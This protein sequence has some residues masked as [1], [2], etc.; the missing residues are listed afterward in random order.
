MII[1]RKVRM[2]LGLVIF[3]L[4]T[5]LFLDFTG[6]IHAWFGWLAKMQFVAAITSSNV[7]VVV[8]LLLLT[9]LFGRIYCSVICPLGVFQDVVLDTATRRKKYRFSFS[10]AKTP[11]RIA[12]LVL[13]VAMFIAGVS[14][15]VVILEPYSIYGRIASNLFAPIWQFGNNI[16]AFFAE[17]VD[18]YAFYS[19]DIWIKSAPTFIIALISFVVIVVLA[20]RGGRTFCNT[21]CPVGTVLGFLAKYSFYKPRIDQDKCNSCGLCEKSCKSSCIDSKSKTIDYSRCVTCLDCT[22]VC[23]KDALHYSKSA[24]PSLAATSETKTTDN[25]RK[26]FLLTSLLLGRTIAKAQEI[27]TDGGLSVI[28]DKKVPSRATHV[29]P[30][31]SVGIKQFKNKCTGCQLC[32]SVCPSQ[33]L[34]PSSDLSRFMQPEMSFENGYCRPECTA[35]SDVCPTGAIISVTKEEK[36]AISIGTAT[37]IKDNCVV[38]TDDVTCGNCATRCPSGAI[39]MIPVSGTTTDTPSQG[40]GTSGNAPSGGQQ[41]RGG[42]GGGQDRGGQGGG[43][44]R[45]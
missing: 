43:Q 3:A 23:K 36:S 41:D 10:K 5:L 13:F 40:S 30:A 21:I 34:R 42:Q 20:W 31:G 33:V 4:I 19:T 11:L 8:I 35:C 18:S 7:V 22:V 15:V 1:L 25:G 16:L 39:M 26:T 32:V 27:K 12:I 14:A 9:M 2:T 38:L 29:L 24:K 44:D 28:V 17:R 37:W 45:G 6:S